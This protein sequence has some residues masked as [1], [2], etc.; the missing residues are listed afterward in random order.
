MNCHR[1]RH[2]LFNPEHKANGNG[3]LE[4]LSLAQTFQ[5]RFRSQTKVAIIAPFSNLTI[6][7]TD[8]IAEERE[9]KRESGD[10]LIVGR[11]SKLSAAAISVLSALCKRFLSTAG[12]SPKRLITSKGWE[13]SCSLGEILFPGYKMDSQRHSWII[14]FGCKVLPQIGERC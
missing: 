10:A 6:I 12:G 3:R 5:Q 9:R 4:F 7:T 2:R 13:I 14:H 8:S 11:L 1:A